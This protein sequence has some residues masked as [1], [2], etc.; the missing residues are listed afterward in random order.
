MKKLFLF[1]VLPALA[2]A[3]EIDVVIHVI[4]LEQQKGA[5]YAGLYDSEHWA[6]DQRLATTKV[7][8]DGTDATLHLPA[9]GPGTYAVKMFHDLNG[10]GVLDKTFGIPDEPYAF[11][12]N[13]KA[14]FGPPK[15][16]DAAF[17]VTEQGALV[18][19]T[20]R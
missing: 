2:Q 16:A 17:A 4:G 10:N 8:V 1:L 20:L 19:I 12:N 3:E 11:S 9:P 5:I 6:G 14:G 7:T 15:F 13:A 18:T